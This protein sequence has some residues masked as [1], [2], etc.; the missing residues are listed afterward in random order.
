MRRAR[1]QTAW[2]PNQSLAFNASFGNGS[3]RSVQPFDPAR[4]TIAMLAG[5]RPNSA[6]DV[7]V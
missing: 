3:R 1:A 6:A 4:L 7:E 5:R 2:L